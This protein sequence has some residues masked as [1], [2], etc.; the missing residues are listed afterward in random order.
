MKTAIRWALWI[1]AVIAGVALGY[2]S[3]V[4]RCSWE[5]CH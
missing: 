5:A 4:I 1:A 2:Y 3:E